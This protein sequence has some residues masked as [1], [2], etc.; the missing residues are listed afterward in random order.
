MFMK[1]AI[2]CVGSSGAGRYR[3]ALVTPGLFPKGGH[4]DNQRCQLT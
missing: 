4:I 1:P 2:P 3:F